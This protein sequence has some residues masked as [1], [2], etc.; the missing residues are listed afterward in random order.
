[1]KHCNIRAG[2][3]SG[4]EFL[5]DCSSFSCQPQD[6]PNGQPAQPQKQKNQ[7][8]LETLMEPVQ[9]ATREKGISSSN[10]TSN[11]NPKIFLQVNCLVPI[12]ITCLHC[13]GV[14]SFLSLT[15]TFPYISEL[16]HNFRQL[17]NYIKYA[18]GLRRRTCF[19]SWWLPKVYLGRLW[20]ESCGP[21]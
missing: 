15:F 17:K 20:A 13:Y 6:G 9:P 11:F 16:W 5:S 2:N 1:M 12:N 3:C 18:K 4:D 14:S 8:V 19:S 21:P 7:S 10:L